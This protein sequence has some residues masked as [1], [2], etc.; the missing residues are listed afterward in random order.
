MAKHLTVRKAAPTAESYL[1]QNSVKFEK[2]RERKTVSLIEESGMWK[3]P[4]KA[5]RLRGS[6]ST[7]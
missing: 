1:G 3:H 5:V 6:E 7:G 4:S 2:H